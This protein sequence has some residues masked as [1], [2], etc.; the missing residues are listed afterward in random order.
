MKKAMLMLFAMA[1][2]VCAAAAGFGGAAD[3]T[4]QEAFDHKWDE[5]QYHDH[6]YDHH[7][8]CTMIC[9]GTK[10]YDKCSCD[11]HSAEQCDKS[12]E[13][14]HVECRV[15][16]ECDECGITFCDGRCDECGERCD[17]YEYC[18]GCGA[19]YS[20]M[21]ADGY[22]DNCGRDCYC[23]Q[24]CKACGHNHYFNGYCDECA[25]RCYYARC[26]HDSYDMNCPECQDRC[27][28]D[29]PSC[30]KL[31]DKC[32]SCMEEES[33]ADAEPTVFTI[34]LGEESSADAK[35]EMQGYPDMEG[36]DIEPALLNGYADQM[37]SSNSPADE[38]QAS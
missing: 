10:P 35:P 36:M 28:D 17:V 31:P 26:C 19:K 12:F 37:P 7:D 20:C 1:F 23:F 4:R 8:L 24:K 13:K 33:G 25:G 16:E 29:A 18:S 9:P 30:D 21:H 2:I 32:S 38:A 14:H 27:K 5:G 34:Y 6:N 15:F 22:C 3:S 11:H